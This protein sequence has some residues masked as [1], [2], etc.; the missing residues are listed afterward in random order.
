MNA[1][2]FPWTELDRYVLPGKLS[3]TER[4]GS[5][6]AENKIPSA[7]IFILSFLF[8]GFIA[9]SEC[10]MVTEARSQGTITVVKLGV[11]AK[12]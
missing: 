8:S 6:R 3:F 5:N 1:I 7:Y 4:E 10:P 11:E 12:G 2:T 9:W